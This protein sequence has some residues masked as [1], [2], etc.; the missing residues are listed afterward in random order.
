MKKVLII[1]AAIFM[2][3]LLNPVKAQDCEAI[4]GP[5]L[6]RILSCQRGP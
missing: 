1:T 5:Y 2:L 6:E 3:G 4:V